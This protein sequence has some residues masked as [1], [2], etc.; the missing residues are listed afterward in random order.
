MLITLDPHHI[1]WS[2]FAY[3]YFFLKKIGRKKWQGKQIVARGFKTLCVRLLDYKKAPLTILPQRIV[4][5]LDTTYISFTYAR[6][7]KIAR[8]WVFTIV[9]DP[10]VCILITMWVSHESWI[11]T[12]ILHDPWVCTIIIMWAR[13]SARPWSVSEN[14]H[15]GS[16]T[17]LSVN[18]WFKL[19]LQFYCTRRRIWYA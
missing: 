2:K 16:C 18:C 1:F 9:H 14:A 19:D 11:C 15:H 8:P 3:L 7:I 10:R 5:M 4:Y 6:P 17:F 13:L 12:I